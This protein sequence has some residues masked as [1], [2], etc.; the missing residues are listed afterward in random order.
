M[1]YKNE[2]SKI[3]WSKVNIVLWGATKNSVLPWLYIEGL[4]YNTLLFREA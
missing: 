4:I 2:E 1:K 3:Q